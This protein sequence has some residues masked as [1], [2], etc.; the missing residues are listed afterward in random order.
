[1]LANGFNVLAHC[2][3]ARRDTWIWS[4]ATGWQ[5]AAESGPSARHSMAMAGILPPSAS[6]AIVLFG[7]SAAEQSS[8]MNPETWVWTDGGGWNQWTSNEAERAVAVPPWAAMTASGD[9][10]QITMWGAEIQSTIGHTACTLHTHV[11]QHTHA[12]IHS[13]LL[14]RCAGHADSQQHVGLC[15]GGWMEPQEET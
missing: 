9:Q 12:R 1:M 5:L 13:L 11:I 14:G 2:S 8:R 3:R 4:R 7:G 15:L 6:G 10:S